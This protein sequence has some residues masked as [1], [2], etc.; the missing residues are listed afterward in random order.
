MSLPTNK[1][2]RAYVPKKVREKF[3]Y[4]RSKHLV[5]IVVTRTR[6]LFSSSLSK[7]IYRSLVQQFEAQTNHKDRGGQAKS[8]F[9]L[10]LLS[11]PG[12]TSARDAF[13]PRPDSSSGLTPPPSTLSTPALIQREYKVGSRSVQ[14]CPLVSDARALICKVTVVSDT[15]NHVKR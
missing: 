4:D 7:R 15:P 6:T 13:R 1:L 5:A 8:Q 11:K 14:G 10:K 9:M 2:N 12:E 3:R